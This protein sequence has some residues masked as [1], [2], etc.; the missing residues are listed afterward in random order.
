MFSHLDLKDSKVTDVDYLLN[1]GRL[2]EATKV[3][4]AISVKLREAYSQEQQRSTG[5]QLD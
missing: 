2:A 5:E 3:L 1:K 4:L